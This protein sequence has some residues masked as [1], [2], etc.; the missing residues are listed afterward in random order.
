MKSV[1]DALPRTR[2]LAALAISAVLAS[3]AQAAPGAAHD[4]HAHAAGAASPKAASSNASVPLPFDTR[5]FA[6]LLKTGPRPAAYLFTTS[7]CATCPEAFEVLHQAL[8]DAGREAELAAVMMDLGGTR[9]QRHAAHFE[10]ITRLY[11]FDGF[12]PAIR[13]SVDPK[14]PNI[15]PYIVMIDKAGKVQRTIGPPDQ[16]A[17]AVWLK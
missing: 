9:A 11:T 5:T 6:R 12:E 4:A 14:W 1:F 3:V 16:A 10:G 7:Y 17:L 15:T 13:Q 8:V 2:W